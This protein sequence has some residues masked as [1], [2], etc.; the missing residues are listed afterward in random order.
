LFYSSSVNHTQKNQHLKLAATY[1][2]FKESTIG[3]RGLN[4]RVRNENGCTPAAKPP[5]LKADFNDLDTLKRCRPSMQNIRDG[6]STQRTL[7]NKSD[8]SEQ[9]DLNP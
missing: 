5:T 2:P 1:S 7:L 9:W 6:S 4:F 3:A 8:W